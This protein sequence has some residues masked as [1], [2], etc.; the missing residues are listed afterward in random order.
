MGINE[1]RRLS[2]VGHVS[3]LVELD[4]G[5]E[6]AEDPDVVAIG[7]PEDDGTGD[8][9]EEILIDAAAGAVESMPRKQR[10]D[11]DKVGEAVRRAVRGAA[12]DAWGKKP[13]ATV[14]VTRS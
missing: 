13:I 11:L 10:K 6:L 4:E 12:A 8:D 14:F 2:F 7:L 3:V 1:R 5:L 9:M